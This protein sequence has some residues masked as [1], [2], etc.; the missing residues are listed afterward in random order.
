MPKYI[1]IYNELKKRIVSGYYPQNSQL[2]EGKKLAFFFDCSELTITRALNILVKEGFV[3]R[4]RGLGSFVKVPFNASFTNHLKGTTARCME[5]GQVIETRVIEF[6]ALPASEEIQEKL[7][8]SS[9]EMVYSIMRVRVINGIPSIIE[10]TYMPVRII[11][12]LNNSTVEHSIYNY[13][14]E[15][16]GYNVH[17][18]H[19]IV[20]A[21]I[22]NEQQ[23]E[24]LELSVPEVVI[25]VEQTAYLDNGKLFE[26]SIATHRYNTFKFATEFI[27]YN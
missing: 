14:T 1:D 7:Q 4:K 9:D 8:L 6:F 24:L 20:T 15:G 10:R 26:Y 11:P 17:S 25:H 19:M 2:P 16:L 12:G 13:I 23:S 21:N 27:R 5:S 22:S 3:V 18:S